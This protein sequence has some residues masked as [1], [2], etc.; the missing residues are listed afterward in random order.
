MQYGN[1][2]DLPTLNFAISEMG[3]LQEVFN[4]DLWPHV[5]MKMGASPSVSKVLMSN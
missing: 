5:A 1:D 4:K 2:I 3:G